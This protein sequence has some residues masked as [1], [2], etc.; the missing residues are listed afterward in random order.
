[1]YSLTFLVLSEMTLGYTFFWWLTLLVRVS[2][3][4]QVVGMNFTS[5]NFDSCSNLFF[6][7]PAESYIMKIHC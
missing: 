1:M 6:S 4:G 7:L 5:I 2:Y 3:R